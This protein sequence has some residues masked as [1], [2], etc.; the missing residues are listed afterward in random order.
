MAP[1]RMVIY[2]YSQVIDESLD[3]W[4]TWVFTCR[5]D[6]ETAGT[7]RVMIGSKWLLKGRGIETRAAPEPIISNRYPISDGSRGIR[8]RQQR[9]GDQRF[10]WLL[11]GCTKTFILGRR[12]DEHIGRRRPQ[13]LRRITPRE[14]RRC[15]LNC[16]LRYIV[17]SSEKDSLCSQRV[18]S[19]ISPP[20]R[21]SPSS[22]TFLLHWEINIVWSPRTHCFSGCCNRH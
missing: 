6:K 11:S 15:P 3:A 17:V 1:H 4:G 16:S 10:I 7:H 5:I 2:L 14:P 8:R 21:L 20:S 13:R 12:D 22:S 19:L 18:V 9:Q